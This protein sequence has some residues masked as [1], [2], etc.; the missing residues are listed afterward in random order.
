M[1]Y[2]NIVTGEIKTL[3]DWIMVCNESNIDDLS[4]NLVEIDSCGSYL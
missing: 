4:Y 1:M 2:E 3:S